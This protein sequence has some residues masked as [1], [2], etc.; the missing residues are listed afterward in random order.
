MRIFTV[1]FIFHLK[2]TSSLLSML[3]KTYGKSSIHPFSNEGTL[4]YL[5]HEKWYPR[6]VDHYHHHNYSNSNQIKNTLL[7]FTT[8]NDK[9]CMSSGI[10]TTWIDNITVRDAPLDFQGDRKFLEKKIT[11]S[12]RR[13]FCCWNFQKKNTL[14]KVTKKKIHPPL[15]DEKKSPPDKTSYP[16]PGNLLVRP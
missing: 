12:P 1:K 6:Y 14:T 10:I 4:E 8:S 9:L 7:F 11:L 13:F 2:T 15:S 3:R 5:V 16:L